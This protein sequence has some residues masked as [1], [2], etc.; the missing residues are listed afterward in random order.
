[1]KQVLESQKTRFEWNIPLT[2]IC[3]IERSWRQCVGTIQKHHTVEAAEGSQLL[4]PSPLQDFFSSWEQQQQRRR[5][6]SEQKI[7][8]Q[9]QWLTSVLRT[10]LRAGKCLITV[11]VGAYMVE[12]YLFGEIKV[13]YDKRESTY[14]KRAGLWQK[15][16]KTPYIPAYWKRNN[17]PQ[18]DTHRLQKMSFCF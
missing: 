1:M 9:A 15:I 12:H 8:K 16:W 10:Q 11:Y 18:T 2:V 13:E 17:A 7:C 3:S 6:W 5:Q 4:S 14:N